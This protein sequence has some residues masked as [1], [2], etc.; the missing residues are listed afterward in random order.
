MTMA[1]KNGSIDHLVPSRAAARLRAFSRE[2]D[3]ALSGKVTRV[4]L[5]GSRA[6]GEGRTDSDYDVAVFVKNI[7]NRRR[8][9]HLLSDIAYPHILEGVHIRPVSVPS[10]L[11]DGPV[12]GT[13]GFSILRDGVAI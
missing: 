3:R 9:D 6:R 1:V 12:H 2:V 10:S 4:V 7:E 5:F 11:L 8:L 13:L